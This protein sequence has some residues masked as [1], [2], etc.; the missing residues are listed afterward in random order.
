[1]S[2]EHPFGI[3]LYSYFDTA[4]QAI[5]GKPASSFQYIQGQTPLSDNSTVLWTCIGYYFLVFTTQFIFKRLDIP[6]LRLKGL[7]IFHNLLL[8]AASGALLLL[9]LEQLIPIVSK[10]GLFYAICS[11]DAWTQQLEHLYYLNYLVKYWEL[12]D[13]MFLAVKRKNIG[14]LHWYHHS[15]TMV[16]CFTQLNGKTSVSWVPIVL[17]LMVHVAMYWYYA[18]T[19]GGHRIWWKKYLTT[20][21]ITQFVIDLFVIYF[22]SYNYFTSTFWPF[23]PYYDKCAGEEIAASFGVFLLTSYLFLFVNFYRKT[24]KPAMPREK[25]KEA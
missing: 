21:Q 7:F 15:M 11:T 25:T 2:L 20:M 3:S 16:L 9:F 12:A 10:H 17:N 24:Y 13:T 19:A 23:M 5:T 8:T 1:M 6:A 18:R 14:F 4:Y 22:C